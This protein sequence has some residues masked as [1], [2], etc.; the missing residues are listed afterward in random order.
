MQ[1]GFQ[2]IDGKYY[3]FS[4]NNGA[5]RTGKYTVTVANSNGMLTTNTE[6]NLDATYGYAVD[7]NGNPVTSF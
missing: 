2:K 6:F 4:T 1:K 3:Y 7:A 5:M